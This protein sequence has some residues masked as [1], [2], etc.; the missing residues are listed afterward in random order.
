MRRRVSAVLWF[1]VAAAG[2]V[3]CADTPGDRLFADREGMR[4]RVFPAVGYEDAFK[5]A[6]RALNDRYG[7][8]PKAD[9]EAGQLVSGN[10]KYNP[11][12][13]GP[14]ELGRV[15]NPNGYRSR[16]EAL[17]ERSGAGARV[18]VRVVVE[19]E[20]P[21]LSRRGATA[22]ATGGG[23]MEDDRR[24]D[25]P[26]AGNPGAGRARGYRWQRYR[27][28]PTAADTLLSDI[29]R[30]LQ[31]GTLP[32]PQPEGRTPAPAP[33]IPAPGPAPVPPMPPAPPMP[34]PT[35]PK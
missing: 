35:P 20:E 10:Q 9:R 31:P 33:E 18:N 3:G 32:R 21:D 16:A 25:T 34:P 22:P 4:S 11:A 27:F 1:G 15:T 5:A 26:L 12:G 29:E 13:L 8:L 7:S 2:A 6:A 19:R 30:V 23:Y 14:L 17:I 28:D 24:F